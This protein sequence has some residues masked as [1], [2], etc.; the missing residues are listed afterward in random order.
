[1]VIR[2]EIYRKK[3]NRRRDR[4]GFRAPFVSQIIISR[5]TELHKRRRRPRAVLGV[6]MQ[7]YVPAARYVY[8]IHR[9]TLYT[10]VHVCTRRCTSRCATTGD[11]YLFNIN[12]LPCSKEIEPDKMDRSQ[13]SNTSDVAA[14]R[15]D[16]RTP[17]EPPPHSRARAGRRGSGFTRVR[18][19]SRLFSYCCT[20]EKSVSVTSNAMYPFPRRILVPLCYTALRTRVPARASVKLKPLL[21]SYAIVT[22]KNY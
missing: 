2:Y 19:T 7:Y 17:A 14:A 20:F 18:E 1:M 13:I 8:T 6:C 5:S 10:Y 12:W 4:Q 3:C 21:Q 9:L 22:Y 11:R 15:A 16:R